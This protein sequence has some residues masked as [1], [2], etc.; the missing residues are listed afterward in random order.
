MLLKKWWF[1]V[2]IA[3]VVI[4]IAVPL[5]TIINLNK[6]VYD[7]SFNYVEVEDP[8]T[9]IA[10]K[11]IYYD[12]NTRTIEV[13]IN[14]DFIN[15]ILKDQMA[16]LDLGLPPKL[17]IQEAAFNTS[18]Q[19]LYV[20]AKYGAINLPISALVKIEPSDTGIKISADNFNLGKK[21]APGYVTNMIPKDQ[22]AYVINYADLG[23]PQVFTVKDI[24]YSTGN[25]NVFIE[26]KVDEIKKLAK[27]YRNELESA[28]NTFKASQSYAVKTF[29]DKLLAEGILSDANVDK[30]VEQILNN[31]E[32]VNSAVL[33]ALAPD[34]DKYSKGFENISAAIMDWAAPI[35]TISFEGS[36]EEIADSIIY[37]DE[38]HDMLTWFIPMATLSEYIDTADMYYTVY[39][40]AQG[41]LNTL[42]MALEKGDIEMAIRQL[43]A[44]RDLYVALTTILPRESVDY[45]LGSIQSYYNLYANVTKSLT[46]AL[47]SIPDDE[48]TK[49]VQQAV[50]YSYMVDD[51][52]SELLNIITGIDTRV[53]KEI[54]EYC[55]NDDGVIKAY[56]DTIHPDYYNQFMLYVENIDELKAQLV[57]SIKSADIGAIA[58]G[59][60]II[61]DINS[62]LVNVLN[63]L[64]TQKYEAAGAAMGKISFSKAEAFINEQA[65]KLQP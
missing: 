27:N 60:N 7:L 37:N 10:K 31:E 33:F 29:I 16:Q 58:E 44:D 39:R 32:L 46:D 17:T 50:E 36:I 45:Y 6:S 2:I 19:R 48:I 18:D 49:L 55:N 22:L 65:A 61:K 34:L 47:N 21:K 57:A 38:L 20:N 30:Y 1:Y 3:V 56:L 11:H 4:L 26:L 8:L 28:I 23:V 41:S 5:I 59:A 54:V 9:E 63:L 64:R 12:A 62:D 24:K 13:E 40:E 51:G 53:V 43:V 14:Q 25:I 35:Q 15:S 42:G 52:R